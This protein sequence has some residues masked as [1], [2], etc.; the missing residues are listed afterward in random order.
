[1]MNPRMTGHDP[2][3]SNKAKR[4][5]IWKGQHAHNVISPIPQATIRQAGNFVL[6]GISL[7]VLLV[8]PG[9]LIGVHLY[10]LAHS[11]RCMD[12]TTTSRGIQAQRTQSRAMRL[13]FATGCL[14]SYTGRLHFRQGDVKCAKRTQRT[15][16]LP[17]QLVTIMFRACTHAVGAGAQHGEIAQTVIGCICRS[18]CHCGL[19][20]LQSK[21]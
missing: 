10:Q 14:V 1:M 6:V 20:A 12:Q 15:P 3:S 5:S 13:A 19:C 11:H 4:T 17:P 9:S 21:R 8:T 2:Q 7:L 16:F 18:W